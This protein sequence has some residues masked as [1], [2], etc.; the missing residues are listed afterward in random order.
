M[1]ALRASAPH[2]CDGGAP[3]TIIGR[4]CALESLLIAL[5]PVLVALPFG[6]AL[7]WILTDVINVRSF[8]WSIPCQVPW[9]PVFFTCLAALTA[10]LVTTVLPL[11]V[12]RR[13]SIVEALRE[14]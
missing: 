3:V 8:G 5:F 7:A 12:A 6:G 13:H 14:E 10:G 1:T 9:A 4:L 2:G 11:A